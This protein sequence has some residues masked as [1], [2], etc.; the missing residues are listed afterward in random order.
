[1][2]LSTIR[3]SKRNIEAKM[4]HP[5]APFKNKKVK[6]QEITPYEGSNGISTIKE[7]WSVVQVT[8]E[9]R[10]VSYVKISICTV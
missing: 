9:M 3:R 8:V 1:M 2:D 10:L 4:K 5:V 6:T 7:F